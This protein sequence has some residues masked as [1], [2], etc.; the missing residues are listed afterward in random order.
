MRRRMNNTALNALAGMV[1]IAMLLLMLGAWTQAAQASMTP[2]CPVMSNASSAPCASVDGC[3]VGRLVCMPAAVNA[4]T[5]RLMQ[6]QQ[7]LSRGQLPFSTVPAWRALPAR[8]AALAQPP[9]AINAVARPIRSRR[10]N[11]SLAVLHCSFQR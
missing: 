4:A 8:M 2:D 3:A 10:R 6:T 1:R 9:K 7:V 11:A 5:P